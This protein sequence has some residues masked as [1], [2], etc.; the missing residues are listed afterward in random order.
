MVSMLRRGSSARAT[1]L[2]CDDL[3]ALDF[4]LYE[5]VLYL[6]NGW[7]MHFRIECFLE[8]Y[9]S[10]SILLGLPVCQPNFPGAQA[11]SGNDKD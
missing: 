8:M 1:T 10:T 6:W 5:P 9:V 7:I 3:Y 4:T 11:E 2:F